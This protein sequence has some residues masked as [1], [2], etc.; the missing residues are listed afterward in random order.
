MELKEN[1]INTVRKI[2]SRNAE[3]QIAAVDMSA[4]LNGLVCAKICAEALGNENV[5]AIITPCIKSKKCVKELLTQMNIE[6]VEVPITAAVAT[7]HS[8]IEH[9]GVTI[10]KD[11]ALDL[12]RKVGDAVVNAVVLS[13]KWRLIDTANFSFAHYATEKYN[14]CPLGYLD[15]A[16]VKDLGK[17]LGFK[18]VD[19]LPIEKEMFEK[20]VI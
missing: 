12:P 6:C 1:I 14:V 11:A 2:F 9:S 16:E 3:E 5:K 18:E 7:L 4:P 15:D 8:Q 19:W 13:N 10:T 20:G 17:A